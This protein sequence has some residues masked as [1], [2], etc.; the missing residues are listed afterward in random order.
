MRRLLPALIALIA[1]APAGAANHVRWNAPYG[2]PDAAVDRT[3]ACD[4]NTGE[5]R[6]VFSFFA[7][8]SI[9]QVIALVMT[10]DILWQSALVPA[11]WELGCNPNRFLYV[12][13]PDPS[14]AVA[15]PQG[16]VFGGFDVR[17]T[18]FNGVRLL[19]LASWDAEGFGIGP[20]TGEVYVM[21]VG[22]RHTRSVPAGTTPPCSGCAVPACIG[23]NE[24][25]V[26]SRA[27]DNTPVIHRYEGYTSLDQQFYATWQ[28][29]TTGIYPCPAAVP[30]TPSSWGRIKAS[31]R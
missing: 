10:A 4:V 20:A 15:I 27:P 7:P 8:D 31:Y 6:L 30:T 18:Y 19:A 9:E 11:W 2:H 17:P 13:T 21:T 28:G 14:W 22:L 12:P 1:A 3:F 25:I 23:F 29:G 16:Q 26:E 24:L 5:E